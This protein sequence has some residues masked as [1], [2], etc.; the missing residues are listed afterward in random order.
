MNVMAAKHPLVPCSRLLVPVARR[1]WL[2]LIASVISHGAILTIWRSP[3]WLGGYPETVLSIDLIAPDAGA[4]VTLTEPRTYTSAG[5][6]QT[7]DPIG[8]ADRRDASAPSTPS[9]KVSATGS[10]SDF[11]TTP[12]AS[13]ASG[14]GGLEQA[15]AR[16]QAS[17]YAMLARYFEYPFLA[18]QHGW[19]GQVLLAFHVTG[20]GRLQALRVA[21]SS[22]FAV[23]DASALH[24]LGRVERLDEARAWLNGFGMDMQLPVIYRLVEN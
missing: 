8:A 22:G 10:S 6:L 16:I 15:R 1:L 5:S 19:E 4:R 2:F 13:V 20:D 23:L 18:R 21:R 12:A 11:S 7:P 24:S 14:V 17:L 9:V 3:V